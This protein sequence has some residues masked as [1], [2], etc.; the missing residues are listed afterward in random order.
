M[1]IDDLTEAQQNALRHLR[2][3]T[4]ESDHVDALISY[5]LAEPVPTDTPNEYKWV[6]LTS[7]GRQMVDEEL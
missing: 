4:E 7:A 3:R 1:T 2:R 5:G 6:R